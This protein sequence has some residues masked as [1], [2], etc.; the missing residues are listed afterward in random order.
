MAC[1]KNIWL[2]P[3]KGQ[4]L[5]LLPVQKGG[6]QENDSKKQVLAKCQLGDTFQQ[7]TPTCMSYLYNKTA[8]HCVYLCAGEA[9]SAAEVPGAEGHEG[10][11]QGSS[12]YGG[13]GYSRAR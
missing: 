13:R 5:K 2:L 3:L 8:A 4:K 1:Y 10:G 6:F 12:D 7:V 11:V 9:A